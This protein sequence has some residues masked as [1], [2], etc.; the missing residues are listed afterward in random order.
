MS[1][2][3]P[4]LLNVSYMA[5]IFWLSDQPQWIIKV[6]LFPGIDKLLH[7][8]CYSGLG[9]LWAWSLHHSSSI[10]RRTL[11]L[12]AWAAATFY[13]ITDEFHQS[14]IPGRDAS[15]ADAV[16]D[17]LGAALGAWTFLR[18]PGLRHHRR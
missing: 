5:L 8:I 2:T 14:F 12:T 16:A 11:I 13:G 10:S 7:L 1:K 3:A 18:L 4:W 6:P 17:S 15:L 9:F